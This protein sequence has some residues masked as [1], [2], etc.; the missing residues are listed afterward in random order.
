MLQEQAAQALA[1]LALGDEE[2]HLGRVGLRPLGGGDGD[3]PAVRRGDQRRHV[4][5]RALDQPVDVAVGCLPVQCEEPQPQA[6]V[7]GLVVQGQ[8]PVPVLLDHRSDRGDSSVSQ[9]HIG[10]ACHE[11]VVHA[12]IVTRR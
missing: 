12:P 6:V 5:V 11:L 10:R 8:Q 9:Q 1:V 7:P 4:A 3:D 2:R